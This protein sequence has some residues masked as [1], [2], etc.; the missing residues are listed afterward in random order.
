[1]SDGTQQQIVKVPRVLVVDLVVTASAVQLPVVLTVP[2]DADFEWWFL[3]CF[4]TSASLKALIKET[5]VGS[6][7]IIQSGITPQT[8]Q[9]NGIYIDNLAGL[10][11]SNGAF[12]IAVPY[13]MPANRTYQHLFTDLSGQQNTVQLVYHGFALL[14]VPQGSSGS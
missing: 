12:P 10:V 9:F 1:M 14:Q 4:R 5:G 2:S 11:A 8:A 6:R 7:D 13:V 3:A